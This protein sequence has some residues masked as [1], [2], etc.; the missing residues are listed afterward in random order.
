ML[1]LLVGKSALS[2]CSTEERL[3]CY[4]ARHHSLVQ[5]TLPASCPG[6]PFPTH[7][8]SMTLTLN[9]DVA[10]CMVALITK[11][12]LLTGDSAYVYA[13]EKLKRRQFGS[14]PYT[15]P[16]VHTRYEASLFPP[17]RAEHHRHHPYFLAGEII[18]VSCITFIQTQVS[19]GPSVGE[20]EPC[21]SSVKPHC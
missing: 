8:A 11:C 21:I 14:S 19:P 20:D 15:D 5:S 18:C 6:P 4:G 16:P 17:F 12:S 10:H 9:P 1:T 3:L 2:C 13:V 7:L